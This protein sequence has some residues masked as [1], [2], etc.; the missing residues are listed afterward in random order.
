MSK[1]RADSE[2]VSS[3]VMIWAHALWEMKLLLRN[4]EQLLLMIIIPVGLLLA[5]SMH[6]VQSLK[7]GQTSVDAAYPVVVS[8]SIIATCFT[9]LAIATGFERRAG[10]LTFLATTPLSRARL[11]AGKILATAMIAALAIFIVSIIAVFLGWRAS[12]WTLAGFGIAALAAIA[13]GAWALALSGAMRAE[14]VLAVAN[15]VFLVLIMFGGVIIPA[16][17]LPGGQALQFLPSAALA[18]GLRATL[19]SHGTPGWAPLILAAWGLT[20]FLV[21]RRTFKWQ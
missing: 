15:A 9:S 19:D 14:G 18:S 5:L 1:Y 3:R 17:S 6:H 11:I 7:P 4:G 16:S 20:G 21:A 13:F 12:V 10:A 2:K 8:V